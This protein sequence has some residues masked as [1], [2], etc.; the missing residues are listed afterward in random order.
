MR[1]LPVAAVIASF[2]ALPALADGGSGRVELPPPQP[3]VVVKIERGVRVWR[4]VTYPSIPETSSV[5]PASVASDD[6]PSPRIYGG[7][8]GVG[9]YNPLFGFGF[10]NRMHHGQRGHGRNS[11]VT[12]NG[13][14][15]FQ[16]RVLRPRAA[17]H[18]TKLVINLHAP[19]MHAP[20][21]RVGHGPV[22]H[23]GFGKM[24]GAP[25]VAMHAGG[26]GGRAH[27]GGHGRGHR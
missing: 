18:G 6:A 21:A 5:M 8:G 19:A 24:G 4:P 2:M 15:S 12:V 20:A 7:G 27:A 1:F 9:L 11:H 25:H 3:S 23:G 13:M 16:N 10:K 17:P 26:H 22:R 14:G